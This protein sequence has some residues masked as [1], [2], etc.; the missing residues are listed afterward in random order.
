[1]S[2]LQQQSPNDTD[3]VT[4]VENL[5]NIRLQ[6]NVEYETQ[7]ESPGVFS[8]H[9]SLLTGKGRPKIDVSEESLLHFRELGFNWKQIS[10]LLLVSRTTLW[11]RVKELGL[12]GITG[13][14]DISDE[15]LDQKIKEIK[16]LH[17]LMTG[18]SMIAGYLK[19]HGI[20]VTQN[21]IRKSLVRI[22]PESSNMRWSNFIQR[23][24]YN[25]AAP[26]CLWHM[27]GYHALVNWG[28]V[29]HGAIDG[30]SRY[31]TYLCCSTNNCKE[32]VSIL[33]EE[34]IV[35]CGVPSRIRTDKGGENVLLWDRMVEL[36]GE[37]RGSFIAGTSVHNQRIE[38]LWRDVWNSLACQFYYTF[39]A[40]EAEGSF[41]LYYGFKTTFQ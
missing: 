32:T 2:L 3:L 11:R 27:D 41:C 20:R 30:F 1:L 17:G 7:T 29:I 24:Q 28:F 6:V 19:S 26:N 38:R 16:N 12:T 31:I 36:R 10:S 25:V 40:M 13:Y 39:Q 33:F 21:Q 18:R 4:L 14:S 8:F 5:Q 34:A 9:K 22:D 15:E 23:R 37:N 35:K